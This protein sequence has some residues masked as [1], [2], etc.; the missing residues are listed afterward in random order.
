MSSEIFFPVSAEVTSD[1]ETGK[2]PVTLVLGIFANLMPV[3]E[4]RR[5]HRQTCRERPVDSGNIAVRGEGM[6]ESQSHRLGHM[7]QYPGEANSRAGSYIGL[8][9]QPGRPMAV[10]EDA[11]T[12]R[13]LIEA[14][15]RKAHAAQ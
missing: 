2:P 8:G 11:D 15:R 7:H 4:E 10:K 1:T 3:E 5:R 9:L 6:D 13:Q 12:V 14:A